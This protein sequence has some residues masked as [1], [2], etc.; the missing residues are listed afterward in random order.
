LR[1][2]FDDPE[3]PW[4]PKE[5]LW[6][7]K[8]QFSDGVGYGWIDGLKEHAAKVDFDILIDIVHERISK[9]QICSHSGS[10]LRFYDI[11][12]V[13]SFSFPSTFAWQEVLYIFPFCFL[14]QNPKHFFKR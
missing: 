14:N 6:R 11:S 12:R 5:V 1:A 9:K 7:Q 8:E 3:T 13:A 2:A 4:L 10:F